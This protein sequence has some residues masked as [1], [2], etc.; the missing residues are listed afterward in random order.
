MRDDSPVC[1]IEIL[2]PAECA[3]VRA[4]VF[5]LRQQWVSRSNQALAFTL[6]ASAGNQE[7]GNLG[8]YYA[9]AEKYNPVLVECFEWLLD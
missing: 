2:F 8:E 4:Q 9:R 5:A 7:G 6:G 1:D 3:R